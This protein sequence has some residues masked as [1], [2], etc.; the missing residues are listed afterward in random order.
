MAPGSG[1]IG[2]V[3]VPANPARDPVLHRLHAVLAG[4]YGDRLERAVLFGS[5]ARGD[6]RPD[7]DY[8]VAV[9]LHDYHGL[10][11]EAGP[12]ADATTELLYNT[13]A[14]VTPIPFPAGAWQQRSALMNEIRREGIDL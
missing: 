12:L 7:S 2:E 5:R 4:L 14:V 1:S 11:D 9:F 13:G 8:D 6:A 3:A 10:W